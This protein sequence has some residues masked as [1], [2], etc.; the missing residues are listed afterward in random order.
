MKYFMKYDKSI[1]M[2]DL[3]RVRK[4][5]VGDYEIG[6]V[7]EVILDTTYEFV[8]RYHVKYFSFEKNKE[9]TQWANHI[10]VLSK[11]NEDG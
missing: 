1:K 10:E 7:L 8:K 5:V 9:D 6:I 4:S 3:I 11:S 2:G